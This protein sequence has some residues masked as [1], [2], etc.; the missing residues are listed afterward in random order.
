MTNTCTVTMFGTRFINVEQPIEKP[1]EQ[2]VKKPVVDNPE[3]TN[4][5]APNQEYS[6]DKLKKERRL[7]SADDREAVLLQLAPS[8]IGRLSG[9]CIFKERLVAPVYGK[10]A[11]GRDLRLYQGI[12]I[13]ERSP[14]K[15]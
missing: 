4:N 5:L 15:E 3:Q 6:K 13:K 9:R 10:C 7:L 8:D 12:L 1:I 14:E 11:E 2:E